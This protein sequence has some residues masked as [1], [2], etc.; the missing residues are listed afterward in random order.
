MTKKAQLKRYLD[1]GIKKIGFLDI[2]T[3]GSGFSAN[4]AYLVSWVL[5]EMD[6]K[7][8]KITTFYDIFT[9][10]EIKKA[11]KLMIKKPS[12]RTVRPYDA[13]ILESLIEVM[14]RQDLIVTHYG[15]WFDIPMIRTRAKMQNIPFITRED[16]I[17]FGDTWKFARTGLK[18]D[19]NTLDL[20]SKT[21]G[22]K[23]SKTKV[24]YFWWQMATLGNKEAL[25]YVLHHNELDVTI[26][27]K[28]WFKTEDSYPIPA[29][30]Y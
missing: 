28:T 17:R 13:R 26:T 23:Q 15:T 6:T 29:R 21:M 19:R 16:K 8:G 1:K 27:R 2:E 11:N 5:E 7:T 20:T 3:Q 10:D 12:L 14:K 18:L 25:K 30:Y 22:V 4:K 9:K 24:D